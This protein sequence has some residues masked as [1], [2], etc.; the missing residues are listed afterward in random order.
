MRLQL[1]VAI[2]RPAVGARVG[3]LLGGGLVEVGLLVLDRDI[4]LVGGGHL[5]HLRPASPKQGY[6]PAAT[7]SRTRAAGSAASCNPVSPRPAIEQRTAMSWSSFSASASVGPPGSGMKTA[8]SPGS[9]TS[10]SNAT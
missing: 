7:A 10:Q 2:V 3:V 5:R 4:D 6:R 8:S 9:S 1:V